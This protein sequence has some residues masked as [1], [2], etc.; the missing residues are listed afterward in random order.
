MRL[1]P[2]AML[3][4]L[5]VTEQTRCHVRSRPAAKAHERHCPLDDTRRI[6]RPSQASERKSDVGVK[7]IAQTVVRQDMAATTHGEL[8]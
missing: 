1:P 5:V 2:R 3:A 6:F 4:S 8:P 7:C